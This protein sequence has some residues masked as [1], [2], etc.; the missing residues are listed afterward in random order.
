MIHEMIFTWI[1]VGAAGGFY[2]VEKVRSNFR[3][4]HTI[5]PGWCV[6]VL[7]F[8]AMILGPFSFA[9]AAIEES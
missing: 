5:F 4:A 8:V 6:S 1:V 7:V 3:K 2:L 9:L